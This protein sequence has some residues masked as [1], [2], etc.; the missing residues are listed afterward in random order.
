M[1]KTAFISY[2]R[3]DTPRVEQLTHVLAGHGVKSWSDRKIMGGQDW[4]REIDRAMAGADIFVIILSPRFLSSNYC[5]AELGSI[6]A[7]TASH[8]TT[9]V[10]LFLLDDIDTIRLP[11]NI[12]S[13]RV[14]KASLLDTPE[15]QASLVQALGA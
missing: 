14:L 3:E 11:W 7:H 4:V 9:P 2:A 12:S 10:I 1:S 13:A 6:V 8:R 5:N 15:G